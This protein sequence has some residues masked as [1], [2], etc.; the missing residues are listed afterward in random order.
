MRD[1]GLRG[2]AD[3][4]IFQQ[5]KAENV[6][7]MTKDKDFIE[8]LYVHKAPPKVIWLTCGNTSKEQLKRILTSHLNKALRILESGNDLVEIQ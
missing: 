2:A 4:D 8:L 1:I 3:F 5:A 7:V 6:I